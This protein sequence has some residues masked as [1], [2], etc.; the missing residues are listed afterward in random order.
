MTPNKYRQQTDHNRR[1]ACERRLRQVRRGLLSRYTTTWHV[2]V[3]DAAR[4]AA[5]G[6]IPPDNLSLITDP[7]P[8][9]RPHA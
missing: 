6:L 7:N 9:R 5:H 4:Y 3:T 8:R 2:Y 1:R